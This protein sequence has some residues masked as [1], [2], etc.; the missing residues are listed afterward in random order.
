[1]ICTRTSCFTKLSLGGV[2]MKVEVVGGLHRPTGVCFDAGG[3]IAV[4]DHSHETDS[5]F[6]MKREK[7][8]RFK[9]AKDRIWPWS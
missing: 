3:D 9:D 7:L 1:M 6:R 5:R 8:R 2:T 4:T